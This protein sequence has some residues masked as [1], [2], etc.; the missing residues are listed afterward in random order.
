MIST[1]IIKHLSNELRYIVIR[2]P[3]KGGYHQDFQHEQAESGVVNSRGNRGRKTGQAP[4]EKDKFEDLKSEALMGH[5][6][7]GTNGS[8]MQKG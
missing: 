1:S 8:L 3:K 2:K 6:Q 7:M 5:I 4:E